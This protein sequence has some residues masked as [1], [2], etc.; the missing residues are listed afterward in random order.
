MTQQYLSN[1]ESQTLSVSI[2]NLSLFGRLYAFR[3]LMYM[4]LRRNETYIFAGKRMLPNQWILP[5]Y[6]AEG[7][8]NLRFETYV[9]DKDEYVWYDG[10]ND[11]FRLMIYTEEEVKTIDAGGKVEE[12]LVV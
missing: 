9:A 11:K 12:G 3:D 10:F 1:E 5:M 6:I 7:N 8:G 2:G 4:D